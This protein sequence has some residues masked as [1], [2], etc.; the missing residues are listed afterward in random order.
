MQ[1]YINFK[2]HKNAL[3]LKTLIKVNLK[4]TLIEKNLIQKC[5]LNSLYH[6]FHW[7]MTRAFYVILFVM[8]G[9]LTS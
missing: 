1:C 5:K 4:E 6:P 7:E 9:K 8:N 2:K 3:V